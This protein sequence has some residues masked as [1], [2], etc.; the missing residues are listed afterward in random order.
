MV[1]S[2]DSFFKY[3]FVAEIFTPSCL[4]SSWT[5]I[6]FALLINFIACS[7][8]TITV[9]SAFEEPPS[10]LSFLL[11]FFLSADFFELSPDWDFCF[12]AGDLFL[13]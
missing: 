4:A 5:V 9:I 3:A 1:P 12:C 6:T 11:P 2:S 10:D 7:S 13:F 8:F